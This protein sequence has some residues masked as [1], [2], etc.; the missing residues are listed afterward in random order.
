MTFSQRSDKHSEIRHAV[1]RQTESAARNFG[2]QAAMIRSSCSGDRL[3]AC[4]DRFVLTI[5][6]CG[7]RLFHVKESAGA[8]PK[9]VGRARLTNLLVG[10][11]KRNV[12]ILWLSGRSGFK[13]C[14]MSNVNKSSGKFWLGGRNVTSNV[15]KSYG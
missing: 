14:S 2:W 1:K 15:D 10:R 7:E 4:P 11:Q 9:I 8:D 5:Y 12:Q 6:V 3:A 13:N